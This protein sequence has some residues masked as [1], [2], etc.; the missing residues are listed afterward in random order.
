MSVINRKTV[1]VVIGVYVVLVLLWGIIIAQQL[2]LAV[3]IGLLGGLGGGLAYL[4]W[5]YLGDEGGNDGE[6]LQT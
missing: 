3:F 4:A 1:S 6:N 5:E 2:L